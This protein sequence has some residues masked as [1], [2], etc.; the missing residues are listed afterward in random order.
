LPAF[1][2]LDR[3]QQAMMMRPKIQAI[4]ADEMRLMNAP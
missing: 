1:P 2:N 4:M 3:F